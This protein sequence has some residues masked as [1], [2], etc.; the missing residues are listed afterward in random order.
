M[1]KKVAEAAP[2]IRSSAILGEYVENASRKIAGLRKLSIIHKIL[3]GA[4]SAAKGED[5]RLQRFGTDLARPMAEKMPPIDDETIRSLLRYRPAQVL[6]TLSSM[7]ILLTTPEF[8]K[9][10]VWKIDP[11]IDIPEE[12]L[13]RAVAAQQQVF[14]LLSDN[15]KLL[16]EI[17]GTEFTDTAEENRD[18][19]L[20]QKL[21]P[22]V[23]KRSQTERNLYRLTLQKSAATRFQLPFHERPRIYRSRAPEG[24]SKLAGAGAMLS[25]AYGLLGHKKASDIVLRPFDDSPSGYGDF[26]YKVSSFEGLDEANAMLRMAMDFTHRRPA[27]SLKLASLPATFPDALSFDEAATRI[28]RLICPSN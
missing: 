15:P 14:E 21:G 11:S 5:G 24:L 20:A 18:P 4:V 8:I 28:G 25:A 9:F 19:E 6:A 16:D 23:E 1:M 3:R 7:G 17:D 2:D 13:D 26:T 10:F 27:R 12:T 22:L